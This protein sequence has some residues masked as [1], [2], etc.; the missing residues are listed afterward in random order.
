MQPVDVP[1]AYA[2]IDD[3]VR[4]VGFKPGTSIEKGVSL[5]AGWFKWYYKY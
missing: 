4:E 2:D 3:L 5:F 1:E